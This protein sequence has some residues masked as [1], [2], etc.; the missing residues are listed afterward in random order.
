VPR[1]ER[2]QLHLAAAQ[3]LEA[4]GAAPAEIARHRLAALPSGDRAAAAVTA[5][6][7]GREAFAQLAFEGA[8][9]LFE[10][11]LAAAPA[12]LPVE[13]RCALLVDAGQA[14]AVLRD[15]PGA[16]MHCAEAAELASAAGHVHALARACLA[17]PEV[18]EPEW[19]VPL[20]TWCARA[21]SLLPPDDG[22]LRAQLLAQQAMTSLYGSAAELD[23][24]SAAALAMA[25]RLAPDEPGT[26]P[27][28]RIALRARQLA[29]GAPDGHGERLLLGA[30]MIDLGRSTGD[31]D[32]VF[33][34]HLWRFDARVQAG[35]TEHALAELEAAAPVVERL[36]RP[37]PRWHL[38][39]SR[40]AMAIGQGR[41]AEA[42]QLVLRAARLAPE[43][44]TA[45]Q[46]HWAALHVARLTGAAPVIP[47]NPVPADSE[48]QIAPVAGFA[49]VAPWLLAAGQ[50]DAAAALLRALPAPGSPRIPSFVRLLI[51][52]VRCT[53]AAALG[54]RDTAAAAYDVVLPY[55]D[56]HVATGA[57]VSVTLGSA[58]LPLGVAA[59]ACGRTGQATEHLR[60]AV[61]AND[62][63]G[64]HPFTVLARHQLAVALRSRTEA[65]QAA[66]AARR[67][68]MAPALAAATALVA[69]LSRAQEPQLTPRQR[70]IAALVAQGVTNRGIAGALHL[71]ER[72]AEN[73]IRNIMLALG[74]NSRVQIATWVARQDGG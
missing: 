15:G 52:G 45:A 9:S 22:A 66:R 67:L 74:V 69:E 72:T 36:G 23:S 56:L 4:A 19:V 34:G 68:G 18:T 21:L 46:P 10:Q 42:E 60:A 30:E 64:L 62:A 48:H 12:D 51:E 43:G 3:A 8:T 39:R 13:Q 11:A 25:R 5:Q 37:L 6:A 55:A 14:R 50:S 28:L 40:V 61:A 33:W 49:H 71:S 31:L 17:L 20:G 29:R 7:A 35:R 16:I 47:E 44:L 38:A 53:V 57:G 63:A 26:D 32:A 27:A 41:F 70:E 73:H 65:A 2:A 59:L 54:E 58:H 24:T 1:T